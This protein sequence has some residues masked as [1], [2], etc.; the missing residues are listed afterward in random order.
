[1]A[2]K[3]RLQK[4]Q[5][6][7]ALAERVAR[8]E[9]ISLKEAAKIKLPTLTDIVSQDI[10]RTQQRERRA[11]QRER[12]Q[13]RNADILT[14]AGIP[15]DK[16]PKGWQRLGADRL[17]SSI[18]GIRQDIKREQ[19]RASRE[20]VKE[21]NRQALLDAGFTESQFP[22]GWTTAGEEKLKQM[23]ASD[24]LNQIIS[25]HI[26]LYIG[27]GDRS[28]NEDAERYFG[29]GEVSKHLSAK[30]SNALQSRIRNKY[31]APE[32]KTSYKKGK[33]VVTSS[34]HAGHA[35][36]FAGSKAAVMEMME[37]HESL[38][39][40]TIFCGNELSLHA[41]FRYTNGLLESTPVSQKNYI[42]SS[43]NGYLEMAGY[44]K[45]KIDV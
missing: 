42:I 44:G 1:M 7:R 22:A 16:F 2:K 23:I 9:N 25:S 37:T 29:S 17:Q 8:I 41:L 31:N 6:K 24:P 40:Q 26:W 36:V 18:V 3:K 32:E 43:V 20:R 45:H 11:E 39:Y 4:K 19:R 13:Q 34:G 30:S 35:V 33:Q 14:S 28:G 15:R 27:W 21:R 5:E 12:I 10:Q 38:G